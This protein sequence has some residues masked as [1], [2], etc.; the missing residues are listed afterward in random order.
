MIKVVYPDILNAGDLLNSN[1]N[2]VI[3]VYDD[4]PE[5]VYQPINKSSN[6]RLKGITING[7]EFVEFDPDVVEYRYNLVTTEDTFTIDAT[8]EDVL[9]TISG[10]GTHTFVD[11]V[12]Q[13]NII[14][15]AEDGT[16]T[17]YAINITKVVPEN[18]IT[19]NDIVSKMGVKV[20]E[21]IIYGISPDTSISTLVNTVTKN[22]G[23]AK[24][25]DANDQPK[26]NGSYVTGDKITISGT[27]D[28]VTFTVSVRGDINGDGL[29]DLKDFVLVQSHILKK[30]TLSGVKQYAGDVNYDGKIVLADFVLIQGVDD[31]EENKIFSIFDRIVFCWF[32]FSIC[33]II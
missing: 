31:C 19:V 9:S 23:D 17:T 5:T 16:S 21:D 4:M 14:V 33:R 20:N 11:G 28:K 6:K 12:F 18:V 29:V 13:V 2:F 1:F 15:T 30:N 7:Q 26:S 10:T 27:S 24:V 25:T 32:W 22:G 8:Q 3:P